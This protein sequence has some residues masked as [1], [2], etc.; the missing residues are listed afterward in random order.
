MRRAEMRKHVQLKSHDNHDTNLDRRDSARHVH[1]PT[2]GEPQRWLR[3]PTLYEPQLG[4][5]NTIQSLMESYVP[6]QSSLFDTWSR[7]S[8]APVATIAFCSKAYWPIRNNPNGAE[9]YSFL[10]LL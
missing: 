3:N 8:S 5:E 4:F 10:S 6:V 2:S 7:F 9:F 1:T